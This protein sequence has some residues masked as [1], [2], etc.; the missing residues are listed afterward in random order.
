MGI[1]SSASVE[2]ARAQLTD[3]GMEYG[4]VVDGEQQFV[5]VAS[6]AELDKEKPSAPVQAHLTTAEDA[7]TAEAETPKATIET[8]KAKRAQRGP[9]RRNERKRTK[10]EAM[11]KKKQP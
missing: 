9:R 11:K 10:R 7:T 1:E 6:L 3:S 5:G 2:Q 4:Y 8:E